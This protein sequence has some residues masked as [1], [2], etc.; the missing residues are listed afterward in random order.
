MLGGP[1]LCLVTAP[2]IIVC[3]CLLIVCVF[4]FA[5]STL[6]TR[7]FF[8]VLRCVMVSYDDSWSGTTAVLNDE[9]GLAYIS[10]NPLTP[11]VAI[12]VQP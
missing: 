4:R 9:C 2:S 5:D 3:R 12:W 6:V 8:D 7:A 11:T 1:P 10:I